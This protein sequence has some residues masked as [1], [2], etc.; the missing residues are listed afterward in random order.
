MAYK[1]SE[2]KTHKHVAYPGTK[3]GDSYCARSA[4]I[5]KEMLARGGESAKKARDPDSPNNKRRKAWGCNGKKST[6][7]GK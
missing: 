3:R 4:G 1:D 7:K 6:K 5:K 2:G